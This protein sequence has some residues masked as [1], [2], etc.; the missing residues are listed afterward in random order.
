M[1]VV[2]EGK[3]LWKRLRRVV[4]AAAREAEPVEEEEEEAAVDV[5]DPK[6]Y[7]SRF[8]TSGRAAPPAP[9]QPVK[10]AWAADGAR[11][12][13]SG[14]AAPPSMGFVVDEEMEC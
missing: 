2:A 3:D 7:G 8:E 13:I 1:E 5:I 11:F 12:E 4:R 10:S 14:R 6:V 9:M